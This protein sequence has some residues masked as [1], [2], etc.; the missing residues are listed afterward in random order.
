[1]MA[2]SYATNTRNTYNNFLHV[3]VL[4]GSVL[5]ELPKPSFSY[6]PVTNLG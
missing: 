6:R 4:E 3:D 2:G 1:M 5:D